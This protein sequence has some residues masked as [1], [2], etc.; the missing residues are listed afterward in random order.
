[1]GLLHF[2]VPWTPAA[3]TLQHLAR[4]GVQLR[5]LERRVPSDEHLLQMRPIP[6]DDPTCC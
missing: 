2:P 6:L 1:M 5:V 3:Q 4:L